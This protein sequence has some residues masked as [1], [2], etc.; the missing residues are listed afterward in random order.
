[1][2][3]AFFTARSC[4]EKK[5]NT[6]ASRVASSSTGLRPYLSAARQPTTMNAAKKNTAASSSLR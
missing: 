1:M 2:S 4:G 6:T 5:L 3:A